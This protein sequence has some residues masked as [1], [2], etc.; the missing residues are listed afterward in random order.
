MFYNFQCRSF[1]SLV[2]F[3]PKYF[4]LFDTI[5]EWEFSWVSFWI[6]T[7]GIK[8]CNWFLYVDCVFSNFTKFA[9]TNRFFLWSLGFLDNLVIWKWRE[10]AFFLIWMHS[11]SFS[12]LI[13]LAG[14][15]STLLNR[16]GKNRHPCLIAHLSVFPH[17]LWFSVQFSS[18]AQ[19]CLTLCDPMNRSTPGLPVHH[20]LQEFTQT[21]VHRLS[22]AIQPSH[23]LSSPSPLAPN[24]S[25]HQSLFQWVN[26][27]HEVAKV[28][29]FQL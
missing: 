20:Q 9:S 6:V 17:W 14:T 3:T 12:Y 16:S 27:S 28:L 29:E 15:F 11:I 19:S 18:V 4:I 2:E 13:A 21:H 25:Q 5:L 8:E 1:T 26:S 7:F 24:P 22:D 23:P 10:F